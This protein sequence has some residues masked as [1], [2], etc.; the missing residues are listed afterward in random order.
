MSRHWSGD[1]EKTLEKYLRKLRLHSNCLGQTVGFKPEALWLWSE[2][3]WPFPCRRQATHGAVSSSQWQASPIFMRWVAGPDLRLT[4]G[5]RTVTVLTLMLRIEG[6]KFGSHCNKNTRLP[7][8]FLLPD[9]KEIK[10]DCK[11]L[12][13]HLV[14][15]N[16]QSQWLFGLLRA[17][18]AA[19]FLG[20]WVRVPLGTW[21][22]V[23]CECLCCKVEVSAY[24]WWLVQSS[25]S[26][27][28]ASLCV[29]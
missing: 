4:P 6:Q 17:S 20:L 14:V 16:C 25:P 1:T 18:A 29:I 28:D 22:S 8:A 10:Q 11:I 13:I 21:M 19:R 9:F 24:Y 2:V 12:I 7:N 15:L 5:L 27:C 3:S 23:C 26:D